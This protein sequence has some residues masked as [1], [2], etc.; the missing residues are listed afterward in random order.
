MRRVITVLIVVLVVATG[1][2]RTSPTEPTAA[3]LTKGVWSSDAGRLEVRDTS[4][5]LRTRGCL[6]G[7]FD[8]PH[9]DSQGFFA[10]N[11]TY[12]PFNGGP[13]LG[14]LKSGQL[15]GDL[16][17]GRLVLAVKDGAVAVAGPF[18]VFFG[19]HLPPPPPCPA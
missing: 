11:G 12:R 5:T 16:T 8:L 4:V 13:S 15:V 17:N 3:G 6:T 18:E 1:C 14:P 2:D 9:P 19:E 7:V 10:V